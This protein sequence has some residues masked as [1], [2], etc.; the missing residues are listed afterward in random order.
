MGVLNA[1]WGICGFTSSLY[2]LYTNS[3]GQQSRLARGGRTTTRMLAEIK[4]YL[5]VLQADGRYDI[6]DSIKA[7]TR[8][9]GGQFANFT[10]EQYIT[11]INSVVTLSDQEMADLKD[12]SIFGI[13]MPPAAVV[14]YLKRICNLRA[15]RL[16]TTDTSEQV[17]GVCGRSLPMYNG[18]EHYVYRLNGRVYT[19]GL[20]FNS[21]SDAALSQNTVWTIGY[22]IAI[23]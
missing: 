21:V 6:L 11:R 23:S 1:G 18:L 16:V 19:W 2:A 4:T 7:F 10:I 22:K 13:A 8:S 15:A 20:Q 5:R 9:F 17:L 12:D 3:P 14:D